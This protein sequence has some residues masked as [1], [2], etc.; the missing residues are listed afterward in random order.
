MTVHGVEEYGS[1]T[2]QYEDKN[3]WTVPLQR[4]ASMKNER[5]Q[6]LGQFGSVTG[7][8]KA[9]EMLEDGRSFE[10]A[11]RAGRHLW[12]AVQVRFICHARYVTCS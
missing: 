12:K 2:F 5:E 1:E 3:A 7:A 10:S 9:L 8:T 6:E 4:V 11:C